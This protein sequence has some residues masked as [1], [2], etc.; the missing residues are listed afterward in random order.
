MKIMTYNIQND[1]KLFNN[2]IVKNKAK[3][4]VSLIRQY[5]IDVIGFQEL[6]NRQIG[7]YKS[8]LDDYI[9]VGNHRHSGLLSSEYTTIFIKK[10]IEIISSNTYSLSDNVNKLGTKL[11]NHNYPRICTVCHIIKDNKKYLIVNTHLD[12][13]NDENRNEELQI[14]NNIINKEKNK[15]YLIVLGDFNM[16]EN[17][18]LKSFAK[19]LKLNNCTKHLDNTYINS[20]M[21]LD[22]I[23]ISSDLKCDYKEKLLVEYSDHYPLV[24]STSYKR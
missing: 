4:I 9:C 1:Y 23:Y 24:I 12:N 2:N 6:S 8:L 15:E 7:L 13:S 10:D 11:S 21:I 17:R 20:K 3:D 18:Y 5:D 16:D 22:H 19:K 14:L